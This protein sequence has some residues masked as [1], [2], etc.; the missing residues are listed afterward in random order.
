MGKRWDEAAQ[1]YR[2]PRPEQTSCAR[3]L[4]GLATD[5]LGLLD[6]SYQLDVAVHKADGYPY[7]Y[8]MG[9]VIFAVR[10]PHN[11]VGVLVPAHEW[12]FVSA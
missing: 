9:A 11:Q 5:C 3:N 1:T 8:H 12:R 6:G 2:P 10:S 7:D 4:S